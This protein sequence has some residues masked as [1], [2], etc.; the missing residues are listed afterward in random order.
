MF[1]VLC[2]LAVSF[3]TAETVEMNPIRKIVTLMQDMQKEIEAEGEKEKELYDKFMCFCETAETDLANTAE[4][5]KGKIAELSSK[6]EAE[7]AEKS[8]TDQELTGHKSDRESAKK[9]LEE[10]SA[11]RDKENAEY[12]ATA[13]DS[14]T[15]IAAL[16]NA[17]PA[18]EQGMGGAAL[19]QM[20]NGNRLKKLAENAE[21]LDNFDR[22]SLVSFLEQKGDYA[23]QSGQIVGI[24]KQMLEEMQKASAE[25]DADEA[26][27]ASGFSELSA[28]KNKEVEIAT[29]AIETKTVR[30]GELAVSTVQTQDALDDSNDELADAEKFLAT[31]K[32]QC[33]EKTKEWQARS[34]LRA[35]EVSAIS[36]AIAI[37]NDDDALDVFKKA[38]PAA[39]AM[40][41]TAF[42]QKRN[43]KASPLQKAQAI[44]AGAVSRS[45][46]QPLALL[47]YSIS[48]QLKL[49][50]KGK[51]T[52]FGMILE[53]VDNMLVILGDEQGDDDKSK[54]YCTAELEKSA[55]DEA[56][57]KDKIAALDASATEMSDSVA[58]LAS[59]IEALGAQIKEVDK[60]VATATAQR[61]AENAE[62]TEAATM[63]EAAA[64]LLE[65]AKQRL[66]KFYNPTLYKEE[67]KKEL[68]MEDSIYVSSGRSEFAGLVQIRSHRVA[69]PEMPETFSGAPEKKSEKSTGVIA[70]MEQMQGELKSDIADAKNDE[71]A[72]QKEY[73]ELMDDSAKSRAQAAKSI[74]DKEASKAQLETKL[75]ETKE[76]KM[77]GVESLEDINNLINHLHT[78]CDFILQ[79]Y[80]ARKEA[81]TQEVE[82]LKNGKAV[83]SGASF[84]F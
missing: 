30:S 53:M 28:S 16:S 18:I 48:A 51:V 80:D 62:Y 83:L 78:S 77:M 1:A 45:H 34:A 44:I 29:A 63:N 24:M 76:S 66:Y 37:L 13:A 55:D 15:N 65:K 26:K 11:I 7:T 72:A 71:D 60:A 33:V 58:A 75:E 40:V 25:A 52:N 32:V 6:L 3:A 79:N 57:A 47:Q 39:A 27:S 10:A 82:S 35:Q 59:D 43:A 50:Q 64:Q 31:V 38:V 22:E 23:P 12:E 5:A 81:R 42:L 9:D 69:P 61:K 56:A 84:A 67:P 19:L 74:T 14:K 21:S 68:S 8:Q 41:Q 54:D 36:E 17:L 2:V 70:L 46:S 49:A 73:E 4:E 20:P